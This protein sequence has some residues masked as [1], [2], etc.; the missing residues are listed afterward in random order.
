MKIKI[1]DLKPSTYSQSIYSAEPSPDLIESI[2]RNGIIVPIWISD[3]N[4]IISGHRRVNACR[5]L[6]IE[7]IEVELKEYFIC[8]LVLEPR[9]WF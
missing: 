2:V 9:T 3:E 6:G 7:E 8:G 1:S 4:V 5:E